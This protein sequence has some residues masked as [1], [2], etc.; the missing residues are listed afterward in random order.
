M[1]LSLDDTREIRHQDA[2]MKLSQVFEAMVF[3]QHS[4]SNDLG[5]LGRLSYSQAM[6]SDL[7]R[8]LMK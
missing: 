5:V 2:M 3:S 8:K 1:F 4:L 6:N 7:L